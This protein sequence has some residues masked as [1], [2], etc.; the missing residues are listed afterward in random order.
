MNFQTSIISFVLPPCLTWTPPPPA[1]FLLGKNK[2]RA[3]GRFFD[4]AGTENRSAASSENF[5]NKKRGSLQA[6]AKTTTR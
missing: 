2:D 4:F 3:A 6:W 5:R 1:D